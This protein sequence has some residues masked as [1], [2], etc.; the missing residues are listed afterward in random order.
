MTSADDNS[1]SK[2]QVPVWP[3]HLP[4]YMYGFQ[5]PMQQMPPYQG[6]PFPPMQPHYAA[7]M[8]WPPN[9]G[10]PY[11]RKKS[12]VG[13]KEKYHNGKDHEDSA[14]DTETESSDSNPETNSDSLVQEEKSHSSAEHTQK[15]HKKKSS[16]TVVIRNINYI[17]PNRRNGDNA[18]E[19]DEYSSNEDE[20]IDEDSIKKKVDDV[21]G[22]LKKSRKSNS[23]HKQKGANK[24]RHVSN[25]SNGSTDPEFDEDSIADASKKENGNGHWDTFQNLLLKDEEE[26]PN[27]MDKLHAMDV[28]DDQIMVRTS[29]DGFSSSTGLAVDLGSEKVPKKP[30]ATDSFVVTERDGLGEGRVRL[31]DFESRENFRSVLKRVDGTDEELLFSRRS[32]AGGETGGTQ[33]TFAAEL[34]VVK[35]A[36]GEDWF[37]ANNSTKLNG[38]YGTSGQTIFDGDLVMPVGDQTHT[39]KHKKDLIDDSFM[40]QGR[41]ASDDVFNSEWKTDI[42]MVADLTSAANNGNGDTNGLQDKQEAYEP[43]DLYMVLEREPESQSVNDSWN[44]DF[45]IEESLAESI[46]RLSVAEDAKDTPNG[47]TKTKN[48]VA[49]GPK[50]Q[51][52]VAKSKVSRSPIGRAK[53]ELVPKSRKP[54]LVSRPAVQKSK[55][56]KVCILIVFLM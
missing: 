9:M 33:S 19:S 10:E 48:N 47:E 50:D 45:G 43:D 24:N 40:V 37:V 8:Q 34:S 17:T 6:Y 31:D 29:E 54:S 14:D 11:H 7:N 12:S 46:K 56:E 26:T 20:Y 44:V 21:V 32:G 2:V 1:T 55:F 23:S 53:P 51:G 3:N 42:S 22:L 30:L 41:S 52:K 27:G 39:E 18:G 16:R 25:G 28:R 38:Q 4:P 15:K 49:N 36:K 35:T 5:G 13:K